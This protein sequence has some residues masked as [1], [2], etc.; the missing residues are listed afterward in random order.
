MPG[1]PIKIANSTTNFTIKTPFMKRRTFLASVSLVPPAMLALNNPERESTTPGRLF[2]ISKGQ[3]FLIHA[4]GSGL[5]ALTFAVP[6][7]VTWQA[8][9]FFSDGRRVLFLSMEQR[10]DGPGKPF[11]EYYTQTPT[12]LWIYNIDSASLQEIANRNRLAVFYTPQLLLGD[13][14]LLVQVVRNRVGQIYSMNLDGSEAREFTKAGEG[15]PYGF[16]LSP[17]NRSIAYH[18]ASPTGY[19][20]WTSD[21]NGDKKKMIAAHPDHLYFAPRWSPDGEWLAFAD[22][23][24]KTDPGHD[25]ADI[26][27]CRPDGSEFRT[28]TQGQAMWFAATYGT[29][30]HRGG[31]SNVLA[32]SRE[33]WILFPRRLP[34]SN[35]PWEYQA[36]RPDSDHFNREFKP[37][38][39]RGGSEIYRLHP[40]SG[41]T[42]RLT[43]SAPL[44]WDFR[45]SEAQDGTLA[46]CRAATGEVPA[47]YVANAQGREPR[48]ISRG[49]DQAG[50][51]HPQWL[52]LSRT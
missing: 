20:I 18:L 29:P 37:Q 13:E 33:G 36:D 45:C 14:R 48:L 32:W 43:S 40:V 22:C 21:V 5:R 7:Q 3:T 51:D 49:V 17:D 31:G 25:W 4:D 6:D 50:V 47:L 1:R 19:Q 11:D 15:L 24:F 41:N 39:A 30:Q 2:F 42:E 9:G 26:A 38:S 16:H 52:P 34:G 27:L 10:R 44:A 28:L 46:F 8:A 35:V 12:H 23:L